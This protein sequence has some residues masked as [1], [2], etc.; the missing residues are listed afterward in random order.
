M[1]HAAGDAVTAAAN[2]IHFIKPIP[3]NSIIKCITELVATGRSSMQVMAKVYI[4]DITN[5][6]LT[7]AAEGMFTG[8]GVDENGKSRPVPAVITDQIKQALKKETY[9]EA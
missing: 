3:A 6:E 1:R 9:K 5:G 4:E 2:E 7:L 8:V